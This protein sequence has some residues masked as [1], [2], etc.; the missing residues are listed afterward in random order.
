MPLE[1][2]SYA[3]PEIAVA[4][5]VTAVAA[6][7]SVR[8]VLRKSMIYGV[9]GVLVAYDKVA[10]ATQQVVTTLRS[11]MSKPAE[12]TPPVAEPPSASSAAEGVVN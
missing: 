1:P 10:S 6:S 2:E 3:E 5:A 11:R 8:K 7:P 9:A 4:V 12:A